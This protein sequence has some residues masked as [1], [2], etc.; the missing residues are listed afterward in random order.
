M[1]KVLLAFSGGLDTSWCAVYLQREK[2]FDVHGV[3]INTGGFSKDEIRNLYDKASDLGLTSFEVIDGRE[4]FYSHV[5]KYLIYGNVLKNNAYPLSVSS[6]RITQAILLIEHAN[7]IGADAIAHGSTGAGNDQVRFD[8]FIQVLAPHLETITPV[9]ELKL[10]RKDE[11]DYLNKNGF[12]VSD[13]VKSYSVNKG[14][15]GTSVGGKETLGSLLTLPENAYPDAVSRQG[16]E[17]LIIHFREGQVCGVNQNFS[18][19]P[20]E[21]ISYLNSIGSAFGIGRDIH[22]GDTIIGIK[23]RVGFSAPAAMMIIKAHEVLEKHVLS[24]HQLM[25]KEQFALHYGNWIHEALYLDPVMRDIESFLESSQSH[26]TG[27]VHLTLHPYYF[28]VDGIDSPYDLMNADFGSYGEM[29][30]QWSSEEAKGFIKLYAMPMKIQECVK[31][32]FEK[33]YVS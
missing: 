12:P 32:N 22:T 1:K 31:R 9:R 19:S 33:M 5:L 23:G 7:A 6:E 25:I 29:N 20:V 3:T 8:V 24:K 11:L 30:K 26:V 2:H 13:S 21:L 28:T 17:K 14:L 18:D 27:A 10:S 15:W 16:S 4:H